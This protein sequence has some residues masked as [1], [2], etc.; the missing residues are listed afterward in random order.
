MYL[1]PYPRLQTHFP[2]TLKASELLTKSSGLITNVNVGVTGWLPMLMVLTSL[3]CN[4]LFLCAD[5]CLHSNSKYIDYDLST[6]IWS[7]ILSVIRNLT[8]LKVDYPI[9]V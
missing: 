9:R 3:N 4:P 6:S 5:L 1:I 7:R 8:K 2:I